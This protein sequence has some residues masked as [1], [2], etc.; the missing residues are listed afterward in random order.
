M[1][2]TLHKKIHISV[3]NLC[4]KN[5]QY[6]LYLYKDKRYGRERRKKMENMSPSCLLFE[7]SITY[8]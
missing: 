2:A 5:V 7:L 1:Y 3:H 4:G 8:C 6:V